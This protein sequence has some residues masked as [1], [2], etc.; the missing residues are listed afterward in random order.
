MMVVSPR[1]VPTLMGTMRPG[2]GLQPTAADQCESRSVA[3][4]AAKISFLDA[5]CSRLSL[6]PLCSKIAQIYK[7]IS[8][9]VSKPLLWLNCLTYIHHTQ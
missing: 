9:P 7:Q 6:G 3:S 5:G 8:N 4:S 2:S 1:A